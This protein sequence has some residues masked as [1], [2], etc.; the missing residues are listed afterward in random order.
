MAGKTPK[1]RETSTEKALAS[2]GSEKYAR[3]MEK[4][5]PLEREFLGDIADQREE[6]RAQQGMASTDMAIA[7]SGVRQ[8]AAEALPQGGNALGLADTSLQ[9]GQAVGLNRAQLESDLDKQYVSDLD[10][11]TAKGAGVSGRAVSGL[12]T[13]AQAAAQRAA[14]DARMRLQ[15][16]QAMQQAVGTGL[17]LAASFVPAD[18]VKNVFGGALG[19]AVGASGVMSKTGTREAFNQP[20]MGLQQYN[21]TTYPYPGT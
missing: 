16:K 11:A 2:I 19:S 5:A 13:A 10:A 18:A 15:N 3:F 12:S 21:H 17:G 7:A 1:M 20:G 6:R 8:Q 4:F 9:T 14:E